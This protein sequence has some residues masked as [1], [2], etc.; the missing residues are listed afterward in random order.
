MKLWK[1]NVIVGAV[2]MLVCA[3][4]Y[5]NWRYGDGRA[6]DLVSTLNEEKLLDEASL[7]MSTQEQP[8]QAVAQ[9]DAAQL[10]QDDYFAKMLLSRQ[11]S[12]DGAVQLL[13]ETISYAGEDEDISASASKLDQIVS[14]A[15]SEAQIE[16]LII[17][18]GYSDCVAYMTDE[19][20]S[21]A[22]AAAGEGLTDADVALLTDIITSQSGYEL[23][24]IRIIE[25]K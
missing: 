8:A 17:A 9:Q 11:E 21:V 13:Q 6:E 1:R 25:V 24:Q 20:I 3:G 4:I 7:V 14:T 19:G 22:V 18:K 15:L 23:P 5:L 12:R 2:L 10:S 16:S